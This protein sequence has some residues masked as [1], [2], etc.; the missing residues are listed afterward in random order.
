MLFRSKEEAAKT[1]G[2]HTILIDGGITATSGN[3]AGEILLGRDLIIKPK[4]SSAY[5]DANDKSHVFDVK[6]GKTLILEDITIKNGQA[7]DGKPGGGAAVWGGCTLIMKGS[8][9]ITNCEADD[10]GGVY[11]DGTFKM[12]GGAIVTLSTGSDEKENHD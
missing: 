2:A 10:G 3:D 5:L 12:E 6:N 4:N 1:E 7:Q 9:T 11:V 8:S